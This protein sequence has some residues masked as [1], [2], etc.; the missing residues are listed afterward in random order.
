LRLFR[1]LSEAYFK[2]PDEVLAGRPPKDDIL[3]F[4]GGDAVPFLTPMALAV[5]T[6]VLQ[7]VGERVIKTAK[8]E[9]A[10]LASDAVKRLF[11]KFQAEEQGSPKRPPRLPQ[12]HMI[13]IHQIVLE[14]ARQLRLSEAQSDVLAK[15]VVGS[16]AT[17][18]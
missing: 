16:L 18:S 11:K 1:S 13:Q 15:A 10:E 7:Y 9:G 2:D 3:G 4:G 5:M 17:A 6:E 14:K 8:E 12:E